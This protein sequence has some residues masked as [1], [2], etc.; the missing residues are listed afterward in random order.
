MEMK[1]ILR[2]T[3]GN[4]KLKF[5]HTSVHMYIDTYPS[6]VHA[7]KTKFRTYLFIGTQKIF[8]SFLANTN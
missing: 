6:Y 8:F 2:W 5:A 4:E 3:S 1:K 7:F